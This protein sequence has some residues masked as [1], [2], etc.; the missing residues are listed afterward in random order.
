MDTP[1]EIIE[2]HVLHLKERLERKRQE[3]ENTERRLKNAKS[4]VACTEKGLAECEAF[5]APPKETAS[6][7]RSHEDPLRREPYPLLKAVT[8]QMIDDAALIHGA[9]ARIRAH[10][11]GTGWLFD[12]ES[13]SINPREDRAKPQL[14]EMPDGYPVVVEPIFAVQSEPWHVT[15]G[16]DALPCEVQV[17]APTDLRPL[18]EAIDAHLQAGRKRI[19][20]EARI[21]SSHF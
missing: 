6:P 19:V 21:Y 14:P 12:L 17:E 15:Y 4:T 9:C 11:D 8:P 1:R 7:P 13:G 18:R 5:L 2:G 10:H 20:I 16:E 3:V